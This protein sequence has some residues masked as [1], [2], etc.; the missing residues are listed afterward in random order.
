LDARAD[1]IARLLAA[2][3]VGT[4]SVVGV[5]VPRSTDMIATVLAALKLGAA[6]LPLDA[7]YPPERLRTLIDDTRPAL[8]VTSGAPVGIEGTDWKTLLDEAEG[9]SAEPLAPAELAAPRHPEHLAYVI[10]TSGSSGRPKGVLGRAGGLAFLL[11]HQR[12]TVVAEAERSAGRPLRVAH[13]YSFAFDSAFDHLVWLLCGHELH[14]YDAE[15]VRDADLLLAAYARDGIDVVDTTPSMAAPLIDGGLLDL[16][17]ALLVLGGE[18]TPAALWQRITA[19]GITA[20]NMYGP[21]EATVDSTTALLS[22]TEPTIGHPLA[23]TRVHVLDHALQPVPPGATGELYLAG[24]HLAR[25]YLGMPGTT[26]ERFVA[27]PYGPPGSRMYRTGDLARRVPGRGLDYLGRADGQVKVRGHRVEIGEVES[28]LAALPGVTAAGADVRASRLVGYVVP[29]DGAGTV[30]PDEVRAALAERLPEHLVPAAVVLLDALPLT[31]NGKLDRAALPAPAPARGGREARTEKE[32][33]LAGVLA[34]VFGVERVGVDDDFFALGG[35][36]I[37]AITVSSRLRAAGLELRPRDLLARRSFA[38]LAASATEAEPA[39]E[40]ADEP[41]G[42]VTAPPIVRQLLDPHPDVDVVAG[43]AQWTALR[44]GELAPA[45]LLSGVRTVLDRH[46]ALRLSVGGSGTE[47]LPRGT[48]RAVVTEVRGEDAGTV[49]ERLAGELDPRR[50]DLLRAALIRTGPGRPDEVVLV[51]HHLAVDGVSW[52][53]L[54]PDLEA[55]CTGGE[56]EPGRARGAGAPQP[57][58]H[59]G[60]ARPPPGGE[61]VATPVRHRHPK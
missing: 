16:R 46:D 60:P 33:V 32:R 1:R 58:P 42:P 3:G 49:A 25:G 34:E 50:G 9:L 15:T 21:T 35:D 47:V 8:V 36:S 22:G 61:L 2:H 4:E 45:D 59:P 44:V 18:A 28:V 29:A 37:T 54:V 55:A 26:A 56:P 14:V 43:Y 30:T 7:A 13:T 23:G 40:P 10:H 48:V 19:A 12:S 39:G 17:P 52:R 27:D 11:H 24:P 57:P 6:F 20:R 5:A 31:P 53:I 41:S 38:A 51:V